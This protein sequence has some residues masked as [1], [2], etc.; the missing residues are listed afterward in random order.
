MEKVY[1][2]RKESCQ[3]KNNVDVADGQQIVVPWSLV[4]SAVRLGKRYCRPGTTLRFPRPAGTVHG[5]Y[6][7]RCA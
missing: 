2:G 6:I 4:V 3:E 7:G 1:S 5:I